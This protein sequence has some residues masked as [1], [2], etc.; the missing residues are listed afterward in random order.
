MKGKFSKI[1]FLV[2]IAALI[3]FANQQFLKIDPQLLKNRILSI[4]IFA[5]IVY[6]VLYAV[7]PFILF[8]ASL[9][10]LA[11]GLAFGPV[12]GTIYTIAGAVLSAAA[13]F[14]AAKK[15]GAERFL[16]KEK[17]ADLHKRLEENGF[18]YIL[19]LRVIPLFPFDLISYLAAISSVR[20]L[21]FLAA[22]AI[23]ILPGTI[24]YNFLG[25]SLTAGSS[26]LLIA[27]SAFILV[28]CIPLLFKNKLKGWLHSSRAEGKNKDA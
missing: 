8:P 3:L 16:S 15:L 12:F 17:H 7:R 26:V 18:F 2:L 27:I 19:L 9:L 11:G 23:G 28:S 22:T 6:I 10:S 1:I 21:P 25:Y 4:G 24:V 20:L 13:A 14:L 5:P